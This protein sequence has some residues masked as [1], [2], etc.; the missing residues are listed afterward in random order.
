MVGL[1]VLL[2]IVFYR[3]TLYI[4]DTTVIS[5]LAPSLQE[6]LQ[7]SIYQAILIVNIFNIVFV[8]IYAIILS[9]L[10]TYPIKTLAKKL[11]NMNENMLKKIDISMLPIEFEPLGVSINTLLMRIDNFLKYKKELFIGSA[12]ELK[13]P[14]AVMK[15]K[16]QVTLRKN[17]PTNEQLKEALIENI[18]SVDNMNKIVSS[19]L[20][21]GRAEGAQFQTPTKIDIV[22]FLNKTCRDFEFLAISQKKLFEYKITPKSYYIEIQT[23]L[24]TQILQ[25]FVQNALRFTPSENRVIL[26]A[27]IIDKK[28]VI[29]VIDEGVGID[30]KKDLFAPFIRGINS[31][32]TGLGLFLAK[33]ASDALGSEISIRN[34]EDRKGAIASLIL[35]K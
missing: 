21:F 5:S 23:L 16:N 9:A 20:A 19:I 11:S 13:T 6:E 31:T 14:L 12:H 7:N 1:V 29:E 17:N 25:N 3:Y 35:S 8:G 4:I 28:F 32:G 2:S 33:S 26:E 10:L 15:T 18:K 30:E 24:L 22:E 34:R 27:K